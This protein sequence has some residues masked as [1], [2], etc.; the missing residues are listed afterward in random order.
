MNFDKSKAMRNAEKHVANGKIRAAISEYRAV[1]NNDPRDVGTLNMLGDLLA[2]NQEKREAVDCYMLVAEH[3]AKQGFAQKAIAIYNKISRLQPESIEVSV[4]L[5]ELY[6]VKGSLAEARAHYT[7]LAEHYQK[8]GRR[9]EALAMWKQIALLDPNNTEVCMTLAESYAREGHHE[10]AA[11][12]Y[13]EAGTRFSRQGKNE[14]AMSALL[15]GHEIRPSDLR[16]LDGL[17]KAYSSLGRVGKAVSLLEDLLEAEPYNRDI[18]YLLIDCHIDSQNAAAAEKAVIKLVEIEPANYPKLL[19]LIRIYLNANDPDSAARILSMSSEYLLAAGQ[20]DE[21]NRWI[22]E[23]LE[24]DP[25]HVGALRLLVRYC[26]WVKDEQAFTIA[27]VRLSEAANQSGSI[28][29]ERYALSNLAAIRPFEAGYAERLKAINEENGF[30]EEEVDAE[31]IKAQF[32][33]PE[34]PAVIEHNDVSVV[35]DPGFMTPADL[36]EQKIESHMHDSGFAMV[37]EPVSEPL[38]ETEVHSAEVQASEPG[39]DL[40][41]DLRLQKEIESISFYIDNEYRELAE[42]AMDALEQEF[43]Q[44]TEIVALR[45]RLKGEPDA[46]M[47]ANSIGIDEMRSEFGLDDNEPSADDDFDT[48]YHTAVAYQE[49]GLLEEAIREFQDAIA[50]ST[51]QDGTRRFF[52][53]AN[54]L[55]HCFMQNGMAHFA[56]KWFSRALET[57]DLTDEELQGLWYELALAYEAEGNAE[58]A[59]KYF[60]QVYAENVDF[61]D[62]GERVKSLLVSH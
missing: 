5:A 53:C 50:G 39:L 20:G 22:T 25:M 44:R 45:A 8:T 17:V 33:E 59:A 37:G 58:N 3:Y 57:A 18:L 31:L 35:E 32:A 49:M 26:S 29:D 13:A 28:E 56:V 41:T 46:H 43:G 61:R 62:V 34:A 54:L 38:H 15:K 23:I 47:T 19:D 6:K 40:S 10:E 36:F 21:C 7:T 52:Q 30:E 2:K 55:G 51:P 14:D 9:I 48:H 4:K 11:E 60:E 24:R 27:L 12:A 42:K 1:V 16:I